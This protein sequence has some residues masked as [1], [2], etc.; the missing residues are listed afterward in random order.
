VTKGIKN[1][2]HLGGQNDNYLW[3]EVSKTELNQL[4]DY[5]IFIVLDKGEDVP[6]GYQKIPYHIVFNV[7]YDLRHKARLV[8]GGNRRE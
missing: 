6:N 7:K 5:H 8:A 2:I 1:A 4:T 3:Q